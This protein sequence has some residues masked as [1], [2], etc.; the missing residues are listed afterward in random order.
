[1]EQQV[2][3]QHLFI[4]MVIIWLIYQVNLHMNSSSARIKIVYLIAGLDHIL[5]VLTT[6]KPVQSSFG[7]I[8]DET[9]SSA[10]L[11]KVVL[12]R[13]N[14]ITVL[15]HLHT[16]SSASCEP[17][18]SIWRQSLF[19]KLERNDHS[20]SGTWFN[21]GN[22]QL[23][24]VQSQSVDKAS[25]PRK[26]VGQRLKN[27]VLKGY[28]RSQAKDQIFWDFFWSFCKLAWLDCW[29]ALPSN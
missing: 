12:V 15:P 1:M 16:S 21:L 4:V 13:K 28:I 23:S 25:N 6:N 14:A 17:T 5:Q 11:G 2:V 3:Q 24:N 10:G 8:R 9:T 7:T 29:I 26:C 19:V 22:D 18:I 20:Q 27:T